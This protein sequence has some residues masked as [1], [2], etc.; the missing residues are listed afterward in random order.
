MDIF[1]KNIAYLY[2]KMSR[3]NFRRSRNQRRSR[4]GEGQETPL[5]AKV[6]SVGAL[7]EMETE[8]YWRQWAEDQKTD[9]NKGWVN[10]GQ[11][12]WNGGRRSRNQRRSRRGEGPEGARIGSTASVQGMLSADWER[13]ALSDDQTGWSG[14]NEMRGDTWRSELTGGR[15]RSRNQLLRRRRSIS[16]RR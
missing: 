6:Q 2:K 1:Y 3:K 10:S 9:S 5:G 11:G 7:A 13:E 12:S 4:R 16:R 15:R 14:S 8:D